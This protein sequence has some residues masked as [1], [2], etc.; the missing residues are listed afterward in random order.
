MSVAGWC[1][2]C[3]D[4]GCIGELNGRPA[5]LAIPGIPRSPG[6]GPC[7]Y[8]FGNLGWRKPIVDDAAVRGVSTNT[9]S[10]RPPRAARHL[11]YQT[12]E[13]TMR[14]F[15]RLSPDTAGHQGAWHWA[16]RSFVGWLVGLL[17]VGLAALGQSVDDDPLPPIDP[18]PPPPT[19]WTAW[20]S[21]TGLLGVSQVRTS[22]GY[23][24]ESDITRRRERGEPS[25]TVFMELRRLTPEEL[26]TTRS[27]GWKVIS[28]FGE[29]VTQNSSESY[30]LGG[31]YWEGSEVFGA[32]SY[33]GPMS[34]RVDSN[35]YI[36]LTD[37]TGG[38]LTLDSPALSWTERSWG[39]VSRIDPET[40]TLR[41]TPFEEVV[42][43]PAHGSAF[44]SMWIPYTAPNRAM[45]F[46]AR[47]SV[48]QVTQ[49]G[50]GWFSRQAFV[51][52]WPEWNDVELQVE[53]H[54]ESDKLTQ[55][56]EW[57]PEGNTGSPSQPG[58]S[59]LRIEAVLRPKAE[60]PTPEQ[61]RALPQVR[62]FRFELSD[63]S[64]EPGV[65][66]N[67]PSPAGTNFP[68][69]DPD[70]DL[71]LGAS[72]PGVTVLSPK[73]QKAGVVELA[74]GDLEPRRGWV[75]LEAYDF[76]AHAD[77][78]VYAELAD[79][80]E[81]VGYRKNGTQ[82]D[83]VIRIPDRPL[84]SRIARSWR[85]K[86][87]VTGADGVDEDDQPAGDGQKGDGYS[88]YEEYRGFRVQGSHVSPDPTIKDLFVRDE[89]GGPVGAAC[90]LL[91]VVTTAETA[92][93]LM[94]WDRLAADEWHSSRIMNPNRS[95]TSPRSSEEFQHGILVEPN[96]GTNGPAVI[97]YADVF[98]EPP[99]PKNVRSLKVHPLDNT[100]ETIA[101]EIAHAIGVEHHGEKDFYAEWTVGEALRPDGSTNRWFEEQRFKADSR[102]GQLAPVSG[103]YRIRVF[104]EKQ[105]DE[106]RPSSSVVTLVPTPVYVAQRG[107]EH[108]GDEYCLMRYH[109]AG[110]YIAK[111]RLFDRILPKKTIVVNLPGM[112]PFGFCGSCRGTG[113]NPDR[114]GHATLGDCARQICV[115]DTAPLR[116][117]TA[118]QCPD[119][120]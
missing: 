81:L 42:E 46:S 17:W 49:E 116:P 30:G 84:G 89:N 112:N 45:P 8:R 93:G 114:F 92:K 32:G 111:N 77:L 117:I 83:Y 98:A 85:D 110:A 80:R 70:Y 87:G 3:P 48:D 75:Q 68:T 76:G 113:F 51:Q 103:R 67:W 55:F 99:R 16:R 53:I 26:G 40:S 43:R 56:E 100:V 19:D 7:R 4:G 57:R 62:R 41:I 27:V 50:R 44:E 63:T 71:R 88:A 65:C 21:V 33:S 10:S 28:A 11:R 13:L 35:V 60:S 47:A 106:I 58:P 29:A 39:S 23:N 1:G 108:S 69:M 9:A 34:L 104:R 12:I 20:Q 102:T 15:M 38:I 94:I 74:G 52:F 18:G 64:R 90:R 82:K 115:R 2:M 37:G 95:D 78:R 24:F 79:G 107:G 31:G 101:H 66:M 120:P 61:W 96:R 25:V 54:V 73:R 59:P 6:S 118:G 109:N 36:R 97:S 105:T 119:E 86:N 91:E 72:V 5:A 14:P 22:S